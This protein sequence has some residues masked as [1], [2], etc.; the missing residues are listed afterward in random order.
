MVLHPSHENVE[1]PIPHH[2]IMKND[3]ILLE[4]VSYVDLKRTRF[5]N[6]A[7]LPSIFPLAK[8][9]IVNR[10]LFMSDVIIVRVILLLSQALIS[11]WGK[12]RRP[13]R[14]IDEF[15]PNGAADQLQYV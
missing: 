2:T 10:T 5:V 7:C 13:R 15:I 1:E 12:V 8:E 14:I 6:T 3:F 11:G 9:N 4:L